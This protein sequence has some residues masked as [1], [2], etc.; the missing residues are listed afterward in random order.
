MELEISKPSPNYPIEWL[1]SLRRPG[2]LPAAWVLDM[3][4]PEP[5][6][7]AL[8]LAPTPDDLARVASR[9]PRERDDVLV[10]RG[11]AR[12][13]VAAALDVRPMR[14]AFG[15]TAT[16]APCLAA[17]FE[18][19]R[20]SF[21]RRGNRF[22]CALAGQPVG[23]DVEI[24]DGGEIPWNLLH[25]HEAA[26]LREAAEGEREGLFLRIWAAKEAYAKA[27]GEGLR[28]EPSSFTLRFASQP[29]DE[30]V[31]ARAF[32]EDPAHEALAV[33]IGF[34]PLG[35]GRGVA[36]IALIGDRSRAPP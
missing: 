25:P 2:D 7:A 5:R 28:R 1:D 19:Y 9:P 20:V 14:I 35:L 22:A 21:A 11:L 24:A 6:R 17:P 30:A 18:R 33:E 34:S 29:S 32:I 23:I 27:L 15:R 36:A 16:G 13:C 12:L 31:K 3:Q 8:A 26:L 10:R 4:E